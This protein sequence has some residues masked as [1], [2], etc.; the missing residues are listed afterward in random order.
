MLSLKQ[1]E[2]DARKRLRAFWAGSSLGR[3]VVLTGV[4]P[5]P[6][7][8]APRQP[9]DGRPREEVDWL[10]EMHAW[11]ADH[12][13]SQAQPEQWLG[14]A[15][16]RVCFAPACCLGLPAALVGARYRY[17]G[18]T[19]WIEPLPDLYNRPL[20]HFDPYAEPFVRLRQCVQAQIGAVKGRAFVNPPLFLDA[21]T[22]LSLLRTPERL[23]LDLI[24]RPDDVRRWRD[25]LT[26]IY[27]DTYEWIYR[28]LLA[29]GHG[30]AGSFF[31][32][33]AEGRMEAVQCDFAVMLSP[34]QFAEFVL[35]DLRAT[36][37]YL[38]FSLYHLDGT[39]Q[40]RF[41]DLLAGLPKLNGIQWNPE[42]GAGSPVDWLDALRAIR[43]RDL[44]LAVACAN[45]EEAETLTRELGPDGLALF[46]PAF[47]TATAAE[48]ALRRLDA[49]ARGCR[50][51]GRTRRIQAKRTG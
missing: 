26:R 2:D 36:T 1:N 24:E 32:L 20:P 9:W 43:E 31:T 12:W 49:S 40:M 44:V 11:A 17:D 50:L 33:M 23:C 18:N 21:M 5:S 45:V 16:P 37:E 27:T 35:P 22:T 48:D 41:L 14:E 19:A 13:L 34:E 47:D 15:M 4:K 3:P 38:D 6:L 10:P 29:A 30:E 46:L 7:P 39:C 8:P 51:P 25:A 42:P 28:M